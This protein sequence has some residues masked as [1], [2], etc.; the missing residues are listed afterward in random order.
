MKFNVIRSYDLMPNESNLYNK[1][2]TDTQNTNKW[3]SA[4]NFV[5]ML[6][7]SS[8]P[9]QTKAKAKEKTRLEP[10]TRSSRCWP[11]ADGCLP[12][13]WH[14][15]KEEPRLTYLVLGLFTQ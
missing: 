7:K 12:E 10:T 2:Y 9:R 11:T 15:A 1:R 6:D 5:I 14:G 8:A 13:G 3:H 4:S